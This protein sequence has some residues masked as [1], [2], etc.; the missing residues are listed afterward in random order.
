MPVYDARGK[1][2][3]TLPNDLG[4]MGTVL[5]SFPDEPPEGSMALVAYTVTSYTAAKFPDDVS[6]S[7]NLLWTALLAADDSTI[8]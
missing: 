4:R 2:P 3:F 8:G 6:L 7:F 5:K 1:K